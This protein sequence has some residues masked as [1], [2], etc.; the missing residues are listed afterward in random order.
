MVWRHGRK[1]LIVCGREDH[2]CSTSLAGRVSEMADNIVSEVLQ[3]T[4]TPRM[5]WQV[6]A[7]ALLTVLSLR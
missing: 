2:A 7:E 5:P 1:V 3:M 6:G 4:R